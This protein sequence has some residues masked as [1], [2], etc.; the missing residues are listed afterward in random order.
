MF[1]H[2]L[3]DSVSVTEAGGKHVHGDR[4]RKAL[5][6]FQGVDGFVVG[7]GLD[8][9]RVQVAQDAAQRLQVSRAGKA[10]GEVVRRGP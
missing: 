2:G 1:R 8:R 3:T 4:T 6:E 5:G 10:D 9:V 7:A